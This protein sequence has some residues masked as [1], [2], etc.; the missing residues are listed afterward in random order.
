LTS[1]YEN[2]K[3]L[4]SAEALNKLETNPLRLLDT[5]IEDEIILANEAP[6]I[7]KFLKKESKE[8]Y[9]KVKEYLDIL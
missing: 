3:H 9:T 2:K 4:L 8:H 6:K 5:K 1:F 7:T